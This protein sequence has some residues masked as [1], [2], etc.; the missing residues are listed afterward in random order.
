M[1]MCTCPQTMSQTLMT[2]MKQMHVFYKSMALAAGAQ[3]LDP[4]HYLLC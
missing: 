3:L 2:T 1:Y 4:I